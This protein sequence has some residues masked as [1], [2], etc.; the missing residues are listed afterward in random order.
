[1]SLRY[2]FA[3]SSQAPIIIFG[4]I[5]IYNFSLA[6]FCSQWQIG[7]FDYNHYYL[8]PVYMEVGDP[9]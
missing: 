1:M 7:I 5:L 4:R 2:Q 8:G 3:I 6:F 9:R